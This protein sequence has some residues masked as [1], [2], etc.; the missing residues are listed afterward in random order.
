MKIYRCDMRR[1][2]DPEY[3]IDA[4]TKPYVVYATTMYHSTCAE[5]QHNR[6]VITICKR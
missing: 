4:A 2:A 6:I 1:K 5:E 3:D